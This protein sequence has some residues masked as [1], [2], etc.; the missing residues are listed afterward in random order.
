MAARRVK[1]AADDAIQAAAG[2]D[3]GKLTAARLAARSAA[4]AATRG[5]S[6]MSVAQQRWWHA[7]A[8]IG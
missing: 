3:S 5:K 6:E 8:V 4:A 1:T 2:R 7:S